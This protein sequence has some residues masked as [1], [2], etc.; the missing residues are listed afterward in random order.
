MTFEFF[1]NSINFSEKNDFDIV[2]THSSK[3]GFM[4]RIAAKFAGVKDSLFIQYTDLPFHP[5]QS[6]P[7]RLFLSKFGK[8][9]GLILR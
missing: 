7:V 2:H 9:S 4:G 3:T 8:N 5:F 1:F 6:A